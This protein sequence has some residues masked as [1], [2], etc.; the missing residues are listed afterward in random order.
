MTN[1]DKIDSDIAAAKQRLLLFYGEEVAELAGSIFDQVAGG[2]I[3][4]AAQRANLPAS[5]VL[6]GVALLFRALDESADECASKTAN[7]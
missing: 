3:M 1:T 7:N 5:K 6:A 2:L 4:A